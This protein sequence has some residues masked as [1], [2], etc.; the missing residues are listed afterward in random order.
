MAASCRAIAEGGRKAELSAAERRRLDNCI[1]LHL[2]DFTEK[3]IKR[4]AAEEAL[5]GKSGSL[6]PSRSC[7]E[8]KL[9]ARTVTPHIE[10]VMALRRRS[11]LPAL[12]RVNR[13]E[14]FETVNLA[15]QA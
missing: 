8:E 6:G 1:N 14:A 5:S 15:S 4:L 10:T 9:L 7:F 11:K 13:N 2:V 12:C 3:E